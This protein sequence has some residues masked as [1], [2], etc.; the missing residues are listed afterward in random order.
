M[1]APVALTAV[2][3]LVVACGYAIKARSLPAANATAVAAPQAIAA[4]VSRPTTIDLRRGFQTGLPAASKD[5][6]GPA[7]VTADPV[8]CRPRE[9]T[10]PAPQAVPVAAL[11][12][13]GNPLDVGGNV[14]TLCESRYQ[15]A[16]VSP[17][18]D[19][20]S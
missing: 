14:V 9:V 15:V 12:F 18:G 19:L 6:A 20:G 7:R 3:G 11:S 16:P 13:T 4:G 2:F 8:R 1:V 17:G 5:T 10:S